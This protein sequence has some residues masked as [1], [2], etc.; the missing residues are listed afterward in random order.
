LKALAES[1]Q[2]LLIGGKAGIFR[3]EGEK[4]A[5][6][7]SGGNVI[8][9]EAK[10]GRITAVLKSQGPGDR[11]ALA[12]S[13]DNGASW[14]LEWEG[15]YADQVQAVRGDRAITRWRHLVRAGELGKYQAVPAQA[16]YLGDDGLEAILAGQKLTIRGTGR[17][18]VKVKH[19]GFVDAEHLAWD[20]AKIILAGRPGAWSVEPAT[21]AVTDLFADDPLSR[22]TGRIKQVFHLR[23]QRFLVTTISATFLTPDGGKSWQ[24][25]ISEWGNHHAKALVRDNEGGFYLVCKGGLHHSKDDG[26]S[27]EWVPVLPRERHFGELTSIVVV[28]NRPVLASKRGLLVPSDAPGIWD[29]LGTLQFQKVK[30]LQ[31][32][33]GGR[34]IGS[35]F[36]KKEVHAIDAGTGTAERLAVLPEEIEWVGQVEGA[37]L[38]LT[39]AALYQITAT[40]TKPLPLPENRTGWHGVSCP[41]GVLVWADDAAWVGNGV[42]GQWHRIEGWPS[43]VKKVAVSEDGG[44]A[45]LT[46]G[47]RLVTLQLP[48]LIVA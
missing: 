8:K 16:A 41:Q 40:G 38:A 48:V 44:L 36:D 35:L 28:G 12:V 33:P 15:E 1:D 10:L 43:K 5:R 21:G 20:G 42:D 45:M 46:D 30:S 7:F 11:P 26:V 47:S 27:W 23:D 24:P 29:W 18:K 13:D 25:I 6:I 32:D 17:A 39:K 19:P 14:R 31:S 3:L 9:L 37:L 22:N 34:I 4:Y 2:G